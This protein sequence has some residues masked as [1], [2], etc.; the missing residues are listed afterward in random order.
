VDDGKLPSVEEPGHCF[1]TMEKALDTDNNNDR[2]LNFL[3][4]PLFNSNPP[5]DLM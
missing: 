3:D 4:V 1:A 5:Y 2:I